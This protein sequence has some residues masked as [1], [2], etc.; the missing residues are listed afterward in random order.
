MQNQEL[1]ENFKETVERL[2]KLEGK[3]RGCCLKTMVDSLL[4]SKDKNSLP[5]IQKKLAEYGFKEDLKRVSALKWYPV[6]F[7]IAS[8]FSFYEVLNWNESDMKEAGR[9]CPKSSAQ[10]IFRIAMKS[11]AISI[12]KAFPLLNYFWRKLVDFGK[13]EGIELNKKGKCGI[14]RITGFPIHPLYCVF[15]EGFGEA[16]GKMIIKSEKISVKEVKCSLKGAPYHEFF[17]KWE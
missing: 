13:L 14:A 5:V 1:K 10:L 7:I 16:L 17:I 3:I 8:I 4:E 6:S 2:K 12:D 11:F 9:N 15:I